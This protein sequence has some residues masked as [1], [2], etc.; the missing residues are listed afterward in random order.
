MKYQSLSSKIVIALPVAIFS[1]FTLWWI[2]MLQQELE[3]TRNMRQLWGATYQVLAIY[4]GVLGLLSAKK[5]GGYKSLLGRTVLA[6][7]VGLLLQ[8]FGQTYSSYY[9]FSNNVEAPP[10]PA[11]GDIGFFGSV[12]AYIYGV[13]LLARVSGMKVGLKQTVN[14][15][16]IFVV[17][18]LLL[19]VTY[20]FFIRGHE[21]DWSN[22][23]LTVLDL[24]YPIGQAL[25][26]SVALSLLIISRKVLG[27]MMRKPI[28][29]LTFALVF[30]YF[31]DFMFLRQALAGTWYVG[32]INDFLYSASYLLMTL[33]LIEIGMTFKQ[34][35]AS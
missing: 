19:L 4:G 10:Y 1:I 20:A 21:Y 16:A 34:I 7:S 28:M 11:I 13:I 27:G 8:S 26:V 14:K 6:F 29:F 12:I 30:Q 5:W 18:F 32:N 9:V 23:T 3:S 33:S 22:L 15:A 35:D 31:S 2:Y 24:G 17:P 25:Y